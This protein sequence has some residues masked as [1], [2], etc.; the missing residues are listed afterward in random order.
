MSHVFQALRKSEGRTGDEPFISAEALFET[1]DNV[2]DLGAVP[3]ERANLKPESR[4][5]VWDQPRT[6]GADRFRLLR[7]HLQKLQAGAKL[8]TL[9]LTSPSPQDGKSTVSLNLATILADKGK[10]K[11]LL[12]EGDLRCP[13]LTGRLGLKPWS[14]LSE[15]LRDNSD[16]VLSLR[17]IEP[18]DFYLLPAGAPAGNPTELLQSEKFARIMQTF[19]GTFDWI[20]IDSPPASPVADTLA[21]KAHAD[22]GLLVIRA[23]KTSREEVEDTLR[24]FGPGYVIGA[25]L[26][27]LEGLER[28]YSD[29]YSKY[30][31][32][33]DPEKGES[34]KAASEK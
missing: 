30:Y 3:A 29:Y 11:V 17:R 10:R 27:G 22:A 31:G 16:P 5:V 1:F 13:S 23:G 4:L 20:I 7:M 25:V 26:N 33:T 28:E 2:H 15:C 19:S 32:G 12:L 21:L 18:M 34:V 8:K 9:L 6:L 24:Q 14:G